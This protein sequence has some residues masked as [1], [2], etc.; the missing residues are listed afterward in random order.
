MKTNFTAL[1]EEFMSNAASLAT[2]VFFAFDNRQIEEEHFNRYMQAYDTITQANVDHLSLIITDAE[3]V[4]VIAR[5]AISMSTHNDIYFNSAYDLY[6]TTFVEM[7]EL[8]GN[9]NK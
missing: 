1:V 6:Y 9:E 2:E 5:A 8:I 3:L 7:Q 4:D